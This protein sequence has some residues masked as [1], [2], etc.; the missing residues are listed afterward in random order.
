MAR[1]QLLLRWDLPPFLTLWSFNVRKKQKGERN[2]Q[3]RKGTKPSRQP[4]ADTPL[5]WRNPIHSQTGCSNEATLNQR[6]LPPEIRKVGLAVPHWLQVWKLVLGSFHSHSLDLVIESL[7]VDF[8]VLLNKQ[9]MLLPIPV[10]LPLSH[11]SLIQIN[12]NF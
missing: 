6:V 4:E 1:E 7:K 8:S 3:A 12:G 11:N 10:Y 5:P 2:I 9:Q